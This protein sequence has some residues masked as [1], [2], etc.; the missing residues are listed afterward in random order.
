[1]QAPL[2]HNTSGAL[3]EPCSLRTPVYGLSGLF[4]C[5]ASY[6][7]LTK[8]TPQRLSP[9]I[10]PSP[11]SSPHPFIK[12][13]SEGGPLFM[14]GG[15]KIRRTQTLREHFWCIPEKSR[16]WWSFILQ[17]STMQHPTS[18]YSRFGPK[19]LEWKSP[20]GCALGGEQGNCSVKGTFWCFWLQARKERSLHSQL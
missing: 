14:E 9:P 3:T 20:A 17:T 12:L 19:N 10:S 2:H 4:H 6:S 8:L 11:F 5:A 13:M 1:M 15:S 7:S 16:V 18:L